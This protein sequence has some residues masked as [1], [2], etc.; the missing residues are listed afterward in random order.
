MALKSADKNWIRIFSII[1][2]YYKGGVGQN[3]IVKIGGGETG[4]MF[5]LS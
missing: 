5:V 1:D 4:S 2:N 3:F